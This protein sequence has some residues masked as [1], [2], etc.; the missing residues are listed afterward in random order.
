[1]L[2][3]ELPPRRLAAPA[4]DRP[5]RKSSDGLESEVYG[6]CLEWA[7]WC[8]TRGRLGSPRVPGSILGQLLHIPSS[9]GDERSGRFSQDM[10]IFNWH[11]VNHQ[12][13]IGG[14]LDGCVA[15][16]VFEAHFLKRERNTK[17]LAYEHGIS[18]RTWYRM[19]NAFARH[20]YS[21]FIIDPRRNG[22]TH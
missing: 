16:Q 15:R 1:M 3:V 14:V 18:R 17:R 11:V 9:A 5:D 10:A 8:R 13:Q 7:A 12:P 6:L 4:P 21:Q 19:V 20:V 2:T 22:G